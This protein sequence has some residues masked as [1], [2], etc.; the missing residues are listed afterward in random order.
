MVQEVRG[1]L[2]CSE[3]RWRPRRESRGGEAL[4]PLVA[5]QLEAGE[6]TCVHTHTHGD[7]LPS[8][9]IF[10]FKQYHVVG[11]HLPTDSDPSPTLY[12]MKVWA[13]DDVRARS[14]FW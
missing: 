9:G 4:P 3:E 10:K 8:Q 12:R 5:R 7:S 14:K 13:S 6:L 1:V 11:R 2:R